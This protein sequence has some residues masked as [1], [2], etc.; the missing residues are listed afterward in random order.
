MPSSGSTYTSPTS[1]RLPMLPILR[2][3]SCVLDVMFSANSSPRA[4]GASPPS[5]P[6][7]HSQ[8]AVK[9]AALM[10]HR[11]SCSYMRDLELILDLQPV[12][13][14]PLRKQEEAAGLGILVR[15]M[16]NTSRWYNRCRSRPRGWATHP[17]RVHEFGRYEPTTG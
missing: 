17:Y 2:R 6:Q 14:S 11:E 9:L 16:G 7:L 13:C 1:T 5:P 8:N 10:L 12:S 3:Q 4:E 15:G